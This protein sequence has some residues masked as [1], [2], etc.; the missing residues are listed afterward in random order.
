MCGCS[1]MLLLNGWH[2]KEHKHINKS[3]HRVGFCYNA[4]PFQIKCF[5]LSIKG[6]M[7]CFKRAGS[8][9]VLFCLV[10]IRAFSM[11]PEPVRVSVPSEA[12]GALEQPGVCY[13]SSTVCILSSIDHHVALMRRKLDQR[14]DRGGFH[15]GS[16]FDH[17]ELLVQE[18]RSFLWTSYDNPAERLAV[19]M[20]A[21]ARIFDYLTS[22]G[23]RAELLTEAYFVQRQ[24]EFYAVACKAVA[25]GRGLSEIDR[26]MHFVLISLREINRCLG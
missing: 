23:E 21:K 18:I 7:F 5:L 2:D 14:L 24:Q 10:A 20:E 16:A 8:I 13:V 9:V 26:A 17:L 4:C 12:L 15:L 22:F 3:R 25:E 6:P 19:I 1:K 11:T